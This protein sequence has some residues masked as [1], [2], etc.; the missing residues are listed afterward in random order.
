MMSIIGMNH[1]VLYVRDARAHQRFYREV[2][3][4][5][6][7][8]EDYDGKYVFMRAPGSSNHHDIAFF[9]VGENASASLAGKASVGL[10]HLAWE[11]STLGEL[12]EVREELARQGCL[13]GASDHGVNKSLYA[14]DPDGLEFEVMWL[15]PS[16]NW[17]EAETTAV[18]EPLDLAAEI[19]RFGGD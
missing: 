13:V 1:A 7:N 9:T 17:G 16:E 3:G 15:V 11:D 18:V 5:E 6:A 19:E 10:Y 2:L 8:I 4:F 12:A 14:V